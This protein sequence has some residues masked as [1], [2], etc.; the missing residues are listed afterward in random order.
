MDSPRWS[1]T[2][3]WARGRSYFEVQTKSG[4]TLEYGNTADSKI[5]AEGSAEVRLWAV[6]RIEDSV[7][8]YLTVSYFEDNA[9]GEYYP[10]QIDYTGHTSGQ[11]PYNSVVF[12]YETRTDVSELYQ[13]GS[14]LQQ[15]KRLLSAK[16]YEGLNL[17]RDY[18]LAY[19]LSPNT[20]VSRITSITECIA[21][22][23]C[24]APTTFGWQ[25]KGDGWLTVGSKIL[26]GFLRDYAAV[27]EGAKRGQLIDLNAD[28]RTDYIQAYESLSG[29]QHKTTYLST[30]GGWSTQ[31]NSYDLPSVIIDYDYLDC[32][33]V[34]GEFVDVN[35]DGLPDWV[36]AYRNPGGVDR[37]YTYIN[38]GNSWVRNTNYDL[39]TTIMN[40]KNG[41]CLR[42]APG[43]VC[44]CQR[45]RVGGTGYARTGTQPVS[46]VWKPTS[47]QVPVGPETKVTTCRTSCF[48]IP[49]QHIPVVSLATLPMSTGTAS[50]TGCGHTGRRVEWT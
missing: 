30:A 12:E 43:C 18:Q 48:T 6:N 49:T 25:D 4:Q 24:L 34:N 5:E 39:P 15:N 28:G 32:G 22:G 7:G 2:A 23:D 16:T 14:K 8:N 29:N 3:Q 20:R 9:K 26:P 46:I 31:P 35:G 41:P 40:Y 27:T 10:T 1:H 11:A 17:V 44:R 37:Q 45:G 33:V 19:E 50:W 21:G 13:A 42:Y 47:T 36:R 38:Q